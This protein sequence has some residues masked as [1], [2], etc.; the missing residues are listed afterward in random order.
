MARAE[1]R[2]RCSLTDAGRVVV[3]GMCFVGLAALIV[4]ALG[5]LSVLVSV[6]CMAFVI[7]FI[8]RPK[9]VVHGGLPERLVAGETAHFRYLLRNV[10]RLPAYNVCT[11]F[12]DLPETIEQ[13][14]DA[15]MIS[16]LARGETAEMVVAIR[17][18]RRG[19]YRI[20]QPICESSFPFNLFRFGASRDEQETLVVLPMFSRMQMSLQHVGRRVAMSS[21]QSG[22]RAGNSPEY[23]GSRLFIPGDSPR[24]IDVRAWAR[25]GVPATKEYDDDQDN[26]AALILDTR[27][28]ETRLK[29]KSS[30]I[31]ELEAA[32]SLCASVAYTIHRHCLIDLLLAGPDLHSFTSWPRGGRVDRMHEVLAGVE[33]SKPYSAEQVGPRLEE[34]FPEISEAIFIVLHWDDT[35]RKLAELAELAGCRCTVIVIGEPSRDA[36]SGL[37]SSVLGS[38][39]SDLQY[40]SADAVLKGQVK[41]L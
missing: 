38:P 37:S 9:I 22:G 11:R 34:R 13:V 35:Y 6:M 7:G 30:E 23:V 27:V 16:H 41:R 17:P 14:E 36:E 39:F 3:R 4:P 26:Y 21:M 5:V 12:R 20:R 32:V 19:H 33:P 18:T 40:V 8:L 15:P 1:G 24:R 31:K 25:L 2:M 10:G 29:A 28:P